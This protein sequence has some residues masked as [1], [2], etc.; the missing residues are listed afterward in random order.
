MFEM[1]YLCIEI[2]V[3]KMFEILYPCIRTQPAPVLEDTVLSSSE[4]I[5]VDLSWAVQMYVEL[6]NCV[7]MGTTG[8]KCVQMH[9]NAY[10]FSNTGCISVIILFNPPIPKYHI[11]VPQTVCL[12][13]I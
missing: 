8:F 2:G 13:L 4:L 5:W 7:Q 11:E 9:S 6:Y 12:Q 3:F 1:L 10:K